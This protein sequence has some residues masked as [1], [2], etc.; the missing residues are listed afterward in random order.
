MNEVSERIVGL[1]EPGDYG[2]VIVGTI[3]PRGAFI[4]IDGKPVPY[5]KPAK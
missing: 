2:T 3:N 5:T 1:A 4:W